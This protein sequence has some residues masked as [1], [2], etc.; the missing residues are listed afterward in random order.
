M[1]KFLPAALFVLAGQMPVFAQKPI[2]PDFHADPSARVFNGKLHIYPSHDVAGAR[3]WKGMAD[4]HVFSTDD[5][6]N[7]TDHGAAFSLKDISWADTEAWAPDCIGRNGKYYFY[8]PAGGQ[9]G[10]AVSDSPAGPF[11]DALGHPLIKK[12]EAGIRYM[13]DPNVFIDDDGQAYLYVGGAYQLG[14]VKLNEDMITRD[15]PVQI[16][17]MPQ[18][19]EGV[20]VHKRN[21]IY[22]ASYPIRPGGG[23]AGQANIMAYSIAKSPLGPWE[24]KGEILDNRSHNVHGSITEFKGRDYLFFHVEGPS[25]WERRVCVEPLFYNADGAIRPVQMSPQ[26]PTTS[27]IRIT[28]CGAVADGATIN[29]AAIQSAIDRLTSSGGGA[30]VVPRGVFLS[31]ALDLK[32]G[33]NLHLEKDAVLRAT[34]DMAHFPSRPTRLEGLFVNYTPALINADRC[35]GLR[36]TG[37]G[38]LDGD[39]RKIWDEFWRRRRAAP[40]PKNFPNMSIPRARLAFISNSRDVLIEG[41]TLKDS[42][43]WNLHLHLCQNA[44]VRN[45]RFTV[46]DD[47]KQAPSTDG[48]DVDCSQDVLIEGCF[49]SVTDDCIAMKGTRGPNALEDKTSLPTGRVRVRD[50]VFKRGHAAVT[51]GSDVCV[52]RDVVVENCRVSGAMSVLTFKLRSD[53]PQTYENIHYRNLVLDADGGSL[54]SILPWKQY[55]SLEGK[56]PPRSVV[57][58]ISISGITGHHGSFGSIEENPGQTDIDGILFSNIN[59]TLRDD[60]LRTRGVKNLRFENVTVNGTRL[61]AKPLESPAPLTPA[62]LFPLQ[63]VRL[64]DGPF[65]SAVEANRA[66]LLAHDPDRL[67][68]PFLREAGLEPRAPSYGNWENT[69]LDGHTAGHYLAALAG[70]IA[71]GAD[72]PGHELQRRLDY[73]LAGLEHCQQANGNGYIGGVPGS[74]AFWDSLAAG[75]FKARRFDINGK[76]VPWYNVHKTFAGLRDVWLDTGSEKARKLLIRLGDWAERVTSGLSDAQ[77]QDMM[78]T[79]HGGM[80]EALAD[81]YAITGGKKYLR[82]AQRFHHKAILDPLIAH[83]DELTGKHANTQIPKVIG[84]ERIATLTGDKAAG[85]G[86][87]FFWETVVRT[88]SVAFG[89]NSVAE[90]FNDPENFRSVLEHRQGPETCNTYNM[91]RLTEQLFS[92]APDATYADYYERALFNHILSSIHPPDHPGYVYFTPLRPGHYRV[93]STPG[94][95][96]WCCVGTGM[97]NPGKYGRFIY[98]RA[99]DGIYVNLFVASELTVADAGLTLRQETAFPD[100]QRTRLTL[101][102]KQPATFAL[103]LRHPGWAAEDA[104]AVR[105]NGRP[106][107]VKSKPSSYAV[108]RREWRDGDSVEIDLPMRTTAEGLPDG[109]PWYAILHGPIVLASPTGTDDLDGLRAGPGRGDHE[110]EGKLIPLSQM[111]ALLT[112]PDALPSHV[113]PDPAAGPMRF[114]LTSIVDPAAPEGLPL[115]PFFRLHDSRYQ[116][117]WNLT[118]AENLAMQK[119]QLATDER[120][121]L[122][123]EAATLDSVAIGGQQSEVDHA[124]AGEDTETGVFRNRIWRHGKWF[125]Y[126]L[127]IRGAKAADLVVTYWGG[128]KNRSFQ[129]TANGISLAQEKLDGSAGDRFIDKRY[130]IPAELLAKTKNEALAIRF[131]AGPGSLAGG[132]YDLRLMRPEAARE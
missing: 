56:P 67:L 28:D 45:T 7:W 124:F 90:N 79:E 115:M 15:G 120:A 89:G 114:R 88:R 25:H 77:M 82:A 18:F 55:A 37:E 52:V 130:S 72:A 66:Y 100:E 5:M 50:C 54:V 104:F 33:V 26:F 69:G 106:S 39:G 11:K 128:D 43:F 84:L 99:D 6:V 8:F 105:V 64:M 108:I 19:Y 109:S 36:I 68:A 27:R 38:T 12:G 81:I 117:Y 29:T 119:Q 121:K 23:R 118:S 102:L 86:A 51:L 112:T 48:I 70:M 132:V 129:V 76:W 53:T 47:Y 98:A 13:I 10:V 40:D 16:L 31:G 75:D 1:K 59:L 63:S 32:P 24:Y 93:Y 85:S 92:S 125:E 57:R 46:P 58:N 3:N 123:R 107:A 96:F 35:D 4:W 44:V 14:V 122:A 60:R 34:T 65:S 2:L 127:R 21:G 101:K 41:V 91:L 22:Y 17:D 126:T 83:K 61:D 74:R 87:R 116:M 42:Q 49:F 97:E 113:K 30:V 95:C 111:P 80:N 78:A 71:S 73:M 20:W 131:T 103:N 62:R 9:I 110:A 94:Q